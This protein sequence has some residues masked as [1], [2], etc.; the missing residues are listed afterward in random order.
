MKTL[1]VFFSM[2]SFFQFACSKPTGSRGADE[3]KVVPPS[4]SVSASNGEGKRPHLSSKDEDVAPPKGPELVGVDMNR[5]KENGG[6]LVSSRIAEAHI[7]AHRVYSKVVDYV[8]RSG[9]FPPEM[10]EP[11]CEPGRSIEN[12]SSNAWFSDRSIYEEKGSASVLGKI[13]FRPEN[14]IGCLQVTSDNPGERPKHGQNFHVHVWTDADDDGNS[15]H[16]VKTGEFTEFT[17]SFKP[18]HIGKTKDSDEID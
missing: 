2:F 1:L 3:G 11:F 4:K 18:Q 16:W 17:A 8:D 13:A 14:L 7:I 12:V 10:S 15:E 9:K 5:I 6:L